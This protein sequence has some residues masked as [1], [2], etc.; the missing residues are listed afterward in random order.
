MQTLT[1]AQT[2]GGGVTPIPG[3]ENDQV[4]QAVFPSDLMPD[5]P[6]LPEARK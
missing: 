2:A 3:H 6:C 5:L 4:F 1:Q